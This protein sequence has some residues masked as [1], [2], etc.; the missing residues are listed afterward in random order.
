MLELDNLK[1]VFQPN[2]PSAH[3]GLDGVSLKL[4][5]GDFVSVI[6][7][8]GAGKSTLFNAVAGS[9]LLDGGK[10]ILDGED[11]T[12]QK[13][14]KRAKNIGR[15]FQDPMTGTAP[16]LTIEENLALVYSKATGRFGLKKGLTKADRE[17]FTKILSDLNMGLEERLNT[18]AMLLSGG[19]R[20]A[21]TLL[22]ATLVPPKLLLLDEHTAALDPMTAERVMEL[23]NKIAS[24]GKIT[25]LMITHN[26]GS[27]L[28]TGNRT[29]MMDKG[30]IVLDIS[31]DERENM[32]PADLLDRYRSVMNKQFDNDRILLSND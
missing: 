17:Y 16:H 11:I 22:T 9:F 10:I 12:Y 3:T 28:K 14:H 8:N 7:S 20:Q 6:G 26:I 23:T 31:G 25:T 5:K 1:K 13:E 30:K 15:L 24:E 19:Q 18:P 21:L 32:T 27:A 2:T 29:I 4:D